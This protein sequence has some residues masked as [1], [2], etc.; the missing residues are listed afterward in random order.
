MYGFAS[1]EKK[2]EIR[3]NRIAKCNAYLL[4]KRKVIDKHIMAVS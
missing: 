4:G 3:A 1:L 2:I